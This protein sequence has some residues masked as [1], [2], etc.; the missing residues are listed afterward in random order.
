MEK[1]DLPKMKAMHLFVTSETHNMLEIAFI[2][3]F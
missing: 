3:N 2:E 1:Y